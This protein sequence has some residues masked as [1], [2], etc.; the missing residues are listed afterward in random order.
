MYGFSTS[1]NGSV[2]EAVN[3]VTSAL[4]DEGFGV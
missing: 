1:F 4:A 2:E 3:A